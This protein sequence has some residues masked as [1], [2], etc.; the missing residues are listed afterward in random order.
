MQLEEKMVMVNYLVVY[1][2]TRLFKMLNLNIKDQDFLTYSKDKPTY[3][4]E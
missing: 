1:L 4:I 2:S 3:Y